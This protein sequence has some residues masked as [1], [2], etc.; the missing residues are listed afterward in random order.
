MKSL[1]TALI[2]GTLL[3]AAGIA[4]AQVNIP[5]PAAPGNSPESAVRILAT[6]ELMVDRFIE[7]WLRAHY[8]GWYHEPHEIMEIGLERYAVVYISTH[9]TPARRIYFKIQARTTEDDTPFPM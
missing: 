3:G 6:S 5:N 9:D 2:L 4:G 7:R 1:R 8:P